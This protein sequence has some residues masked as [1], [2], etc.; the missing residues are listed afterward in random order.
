VV[1]DLLPRSRRTSFI[2]LES[3]A[4]VGRRGELA[5]IARAARE[6]RLVTLVGGSGAG[7]TRLGQRFAI[8]ERGAYEGAGGVWCC[9]LRDARD[10]EAMSA[11]LARTLGIADEIP[12]LG[13]AGVTALGHALAARGRALVVLDNVEQ[14]LP[15]GARVVLRWLDLAA[16][17]RFLVTSREPLF[18][19]GEEVIDVGP[20]SLPGGPR[21]EGDAV[22]LFVER[23]RG[24]RKGYVPTGYES[25]AIA[26]LVRR[27][28]GVPLAIEL[29]ASRFSAGDLRAL[30]PPRDLGDE[31]SPAIAWGFRKLDPGEREVL[32]QCSVF[33]GGFTAEAAERV[34]ELPPS[35][36]RLNEPPRRVREVLK[37]LL[38]K[39]LLQTVRAEVGVRYTVCEGIRAHAA[40]LP[41]EGL[42]ASGAPWR[43][44][45]HYLERS[46]GPLTDLP[47]GGAQSRDEL[48]AERE[49]LEAVLDFGAAQ[50]RGD[51]VVRAAI[52]LDVISSGTGLSRAQLASLDDALASP[53]REGAPPLDPAMVGRAL[54]VR[55]G[56]LRALGRLDEAER[57][58]AMALT[59]ARESGSGRQI[60]AM[61]L[62]VGMARFQ[63]GDLDGALAHS[64]AAVVQARDD[65]DLAAEPLCLQQIG[66]VL[67]AMGDADA[68]GI[69]LEAAL[70]LAVERGDHV[71]EARA[72]ISL[73]SYHL[74]GRDLVRAEAYYDRGLLIARQAG[75][76]RNVRIV[77]G[78][79]GMLHFDAD[80]PQ[81]AERWLD[82]AA[83]LSRA[84]GDLRVEGIFEGMRGAVLATL[85]LLDEAR[86]AFTLSGE[87]LG[88]NGQN[89]YFR[90]VIALHR[91]HLDLA[92]ARAARDEGDAAR[93]AALL[94]AAEQRLEAAEAEGG[95]APPLVKRSDDARIAARILRRALG[96]VG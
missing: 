8:G 49:N 70:G 39:G 46:A 69:Y 4:F 3:S 27:V 91:G 74:E 80:R 61:H 65:G 32:A 16:E 90:G 92:E 56:A 14:L 15:A 25:A 76:A 29:C 37:V 21:S 17:A 58:A 47:G 93:A 62:A 95:D 50:G 2:Q 86:A 45:R 60:V 18:L 5:A 24:L 26:E 11:A 79:L 48:A 68:C 9:D 54:G 83:R 28:H 59:L 12:V 1:G 52:A 73:G 89:A 81:E 77:M 71:A 78:Y 44:A 6:S 10:L 51:I 88:Q 42:E 57:D 85:D 38:A 63:T 33:R 23:V 72:S 20:L 82:N 7:K 19:V 31:G 34:V 55:A 30:L 36:A 53:T 66:A 41:E 35:S 22:G 64:R 40:A 43:H 13:D 87:L 84:V 75:M 96:A 94:E 67:Q